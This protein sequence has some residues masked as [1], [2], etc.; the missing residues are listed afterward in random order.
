[1]CALLWGHPSTQTI[2]PDPNSAAH[3]KLVFPPGH[4][5]TTPTYYDSKSW[6]LNGSGGGVAEWPGQ[7][8]ECTLEAHIFCKTYAN[9]NAKQKDPD[10]NC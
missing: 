1:M 8:S 2:T 4:C 5:P 9:R 10:G 7:A 6:I 3:Q